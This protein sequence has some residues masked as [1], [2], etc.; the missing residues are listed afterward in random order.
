MGGETEYWFHGTTHA[1]ARSIAEDGI[2]LGKAK[3]FMGAD[4]SYGKSFYITNDF[5]FAFKWSRGFDKY[6]PD[7]AVVVFK[8]ENKKIFSG[9][10]GKT[11]EGYSKDW[12][13]VVSYFRNKESHL[14][15]N[16]SKSKGINLKKLKYFYGPCSMDGDKVKNVDWKP[17][18]RMKNYEAYRD[19]IESPKYVHQLCLKDDE[20]ADDF[21]NRGLNIHQI[22]FF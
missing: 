9:Y 10:K 7:A 17:K 15:A 20:L 4:F 21:Y 5:D 11:F 2:I 3:A 18:T 6:W 12:K 1:H 22:L 13:E 8:L 16:I 14:D 19:G